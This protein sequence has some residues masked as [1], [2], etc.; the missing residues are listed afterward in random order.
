M[1][2]EAFASKREGSSPYRAWEPLAELERRGH[3]VLVHREEDHLT[4][5]ARGFSTSLA[6]CD[7]VYISRYMTREAQRLARGLRDAGIAVVWDH[8]DDYISGALDGRDPNG[9]GQLSALRAMLGQI[10]VVTTTNERLAGLLREV[11]AGRVVAIPNQ[12]TR[13]SAKGRRHRHRGTVV[14]WIAWADHQADWERLKLATVFERLLDAHADLRVE[15][16]GPI[17]LGLPHHRYHRIGPV[18]FDE[19]P[20]AIAGFDVG[21]A[22]LAGRVENLG[23]SDIKLKEYAI[24]GVPWLASPLGPYADHGEQQGGRL[25]AD[26]D[27]YEQLDALL[28]DAKLRKQLAKQGRRWAREQTIAKHADAWEAAFS[29]AIELAR[30]R[31]G[32]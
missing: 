12:L 28:S 21:I 17:D 20:G 19:L 7:V 15:S 10:D 1:R 4:A 32:G 11:G 14:G 6:Q 2:I 18:P 16:V 24:A 31:R 8:D 5:A 13:R 23:R 3:E 22:P 30:T 26:G 9:K 27:W 29:E 25:V